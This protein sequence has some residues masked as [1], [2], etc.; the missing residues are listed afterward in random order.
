MYVC[1]YECVCGTVHVRALVSVCVCVCV[2]VYSSLG[3]HE[4]SFRPSRHACL[5][6]SLF[7]F[8][9]A[10]APGAWL[11]R[12]GL[13]LFSQIY[14]LRDWGRIAFPVV[15]SHVVA[16]WLQRHAIYVPCLRLHTEPTFPSLPSCLTG[17]SSFPQWAAVCPAHMD[18]GS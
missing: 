5:G 15:I 12:K 7:V 8:G 16:Q 4:V 3:V 14:P 9:V 2:R 17:E 18:R 6:L 1:V 11:D 13:L 10:L